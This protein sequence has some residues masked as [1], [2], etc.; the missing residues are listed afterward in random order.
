MG[1]PWLVRGLVG[2]TA[3]VTSAVAAWWQRASMPFAAAAAAAAMAAARRLGRTAGEEQS[4]DVH[5]HVKTYEIYPSC[6]DGRSSET[7]ELISETPVRRRRPR[8]HCH[9]RGPA[10]TCLPSAPRMPRTP[11]RSMSP[12]PRQPKASCLR[13]GAYGSRLSLAPSWCSSSSRSTHGRAS[14]S[15]RRSRGNYLLHAADCASRCAPPCL[16][17]QHPDSATRRD[18]DF[19]LV[20]PRAHSRCG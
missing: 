12:S 7:R 17:P 10:S 1:G 9:H 3:G 6:T 18:E 4:G 20:D 8:T 2:G 11:Q 16:A 14:T 5:A 13:A 15:P 19:S